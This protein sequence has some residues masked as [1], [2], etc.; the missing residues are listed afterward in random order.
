MPE[1]RILEYRTSGEKE[2]PIPGL[3]YIKFICR[4][5]NEY[6][7]MFRDGGMMLSV[8]GMRADS[9]I[10]VRPRGEYEIWI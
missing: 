6:A 5:G 10:S 9:K 2:I 4:D 1:P 7:V 3:N 8:S